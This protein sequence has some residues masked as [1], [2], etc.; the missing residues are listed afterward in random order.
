MQTRSE[1]AYMCS[2]KSS[3]KEKYESN[4]LTMLEDGKTFSF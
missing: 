1:I 4:F 3:K 2:F